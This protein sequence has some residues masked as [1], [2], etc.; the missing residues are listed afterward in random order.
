MVFGHFGDRLGRKSTLIATLMLT[1]AGTFLIGCLPGYAR[2][3]SPRRC[4]WSCYGRSR[5]S[6][7]AGSGPARCCWRWSGGRCAAAG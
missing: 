3:G 5:A 1:A 4:C 2:S 6:A 7:W